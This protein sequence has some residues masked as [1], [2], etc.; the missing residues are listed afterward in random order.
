MVVKEIFCPNCGTNNKENSTFCK[1]CGE[2]LSEIHSKSDN[3]SGFV[4]GNNKIL[5]G[6]VV[7]LLIV[8]AIIGT[9]AYVTMN[10][11]DSDT[12]SDKIPLEDDT[13]SQVV[14]VGGMYFNIPEGYVLN[15]TDYRD[16][17]AENGYNQEGATTFTSIFAKNSSRIFIEVVPKSILTLADS[18]EVF[19]NGGWI[20]QD[21]TIGV[22]S[23]LKISSK[24]SPDIYMFKF[25]KNGA[26]I[27]ILTYPSSEKD[28]AKIIANT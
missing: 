1:G 8:V 19:L 17:A 18:K 10:D 20:V 27:S 3:D 28:I 14:E 7:L 22:Y 24:D 9:Y 2:R 6:F 21:M 13:Y 25:E 15:K 26:L 23:G 12:N 5:I 16:I 11:N 4:S